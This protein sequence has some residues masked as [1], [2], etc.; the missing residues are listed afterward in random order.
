MLAFSNRGDIHDNL[1]KQNKIMDWRVSRHSDMPLLCGCSYEMPKEPLDKLL[2]RLER[3]QHACADYPA[4]VH[5]DKASF[6]T[7]S[8]ALNKN[9]DAAMAQKSCRGDKPFA[10]LLLAQAHLCL[11]L[12]MHM[13]QHDAPDTPSRASL[14]ALVQDFLFVTKNLVHDE[15]PAQPWIGGQIKESETPIKR[16]VAWQLP[17]QE[18]SFE[19]MLEEYRL[20]HNMVTPKNCMFDDLCY[21]AH[22]LLCVVVSCCKSKP[23]PSWWDWTTS[24]AFW[25][26]ENLASSDHDERVLT[27]LATLQRSLSLFT[28]YAQAE[29]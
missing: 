28:L 3:C 5:G 25:P 14:A 8:R 15:V 7:G 10:S 13:L 21:H 18:H 27:E 23:N 4:L 17:T 20:S 29:A 22:L 24:W 11:L 1:S 9:E 2:S 26:W 6:L 19:A 16:L 12:G